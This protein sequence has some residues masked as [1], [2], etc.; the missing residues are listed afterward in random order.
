MKRLSV[1]VLVGCLA[2]AGCVSGP[3]TPTDGAGG[4][5]TPTPTQSPAGTV[6]PTAPSAP[7]DTETPTSTDA[8][9][10][11]ST[12]TDAGTPPSPSTSIPEPVTVEYVVRAGS[13]PDEFD[14]VTVHFEVEFAENRGDVRECTGTVLDSRYDPTPT[15]LPSPTGECRTVEDVTVDLTEVNGTHSLGNVT[16]PGRFGAEHALVVRD[17]VPVYENG[18]RVERIH[19]TDFRGPYRHGA[20]RWGLEIGVSDAPDDVGWTYQVDAELLD[21]G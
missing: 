13:I 12:S 11:A 16:V 6:T 9:P 21:D 3:G 17:V 4:S 19:D 1:V 20:G 7:T 15:P 2:L 10:S 8:E 18:T 14:S 5:P